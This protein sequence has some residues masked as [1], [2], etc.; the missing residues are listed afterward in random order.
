MCQESACFFAIPFKKK[1]RARACCEYKHSLK[2]N[3]SLKICFHGLGWLGCSKWKRMAE[4][5]FF[6]CYRL[7]HSLTSSEED[8]DSFLPRK[9]SYIYS[10]SLI[11]LI[12]LSDFISRLCP[13]WLPPHSS[14]KNLMLP[15]LF[16]EYLFKDFQKNSLIRHTSVVEVLPYLVWTKKSVGCLGCYQCCDARSDGV[17]VYHKA[18]SLLIWQ[19]R[20]VQSFMLSRYESEF[21]ELECIGVGEFGAV[22]KCLKRLDGCLYAI[23][24]SR[25]PLAGSANEWVRNTSQSTRYKIFDTKDFINVLTTFF[26]FFLLSF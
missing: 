1:T 11:N 18:H 22:Y 4:G 2:K 17:C 5:I 19:K 13:V 7:K 10:R 20:A 16:L 6:L 23:K 15:V 9:V 3:H 12:S 24:R 14:V 21:L 26:F 8:D 25:R